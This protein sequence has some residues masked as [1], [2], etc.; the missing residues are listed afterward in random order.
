MCIRDSLPGAGFFC[1]F[2]IVEAGFSVLLPMDFMETA[3]LGWLIYAVIYPVVGIR[4]GILPYTP[5]PPETGSGYYGF[6]N[7]PWKYKY[8]AWTGLFLGLALWVLWLHKGHIVRVFSSLWGRGGEEQGIPYRLMSIGLIIMSIIFIIFLTASGVPVIMALFIWLTFSLMAIGQARILGEYFGRIPVYAPVM[9]PANYAFGAS[10][11]LWDWKLPTDSTAL[12]RTQFMT[13]AMGTGGPRFYTGSWKSIWLYKIGDMTGTR[14]RD[15]F[16]ALVICLIIVP[17]WTN[18][19]NLW[20]VHHMGGLTRV[21]MGFYSGVVG[22]V[23]N[24]YT[25]AP[26][27]YSPTDWFNY[28]I[29]GAMIIILVCYLRTRFPWFF[30]NPVALIT[31]TFWDWMWLNVLVGFIIKFIALKIGGPKFLEE[32]VY[33]VVVGYLMGYGTAMGIA[34]FLAF[35]TKAIPVFQA[36]FIP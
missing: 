36:N 31:I 1:W 35:L 8:W 20:W 28:L 25:N 32:R 14:A 24:N 10:I 7:G 30:I 29:S 2:A 5:G 11:G 13:A 18:F 22:A 12:F 33:P 26:G 15:I 34:M 4:L 6:V 21:S 19:F 9:L 23:T 3:L 16:I 27:N 17:L